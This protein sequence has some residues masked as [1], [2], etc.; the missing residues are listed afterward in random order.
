MGVDQHAFSFLL[1]DTSSVHKFGTL[2]IISLWSLR[3]CRSK[4]RSRP[5]ALEA[6]VALLI[7]VYGLLPPLLLLLLGLED[8]GGALP[9]EKDSV[10]CMLK[11]EHRS[12]GGKWRCE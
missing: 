12:G 4:L 5:L 1:L 8:R 6:S 11:S 9:P 10:V 2:T 3:D 7:F